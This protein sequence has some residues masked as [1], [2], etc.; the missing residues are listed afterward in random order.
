MFIPVCK[1]FPH[2]FPSSN[3]ANPGATAKLVVPLEVNSLE[4]TNESHLHCFS[5]A[6]RA[7][8]N[9]SKIADDTFCLGKGRHISSPKKQGWASLGEWFSCTGRPICFTYSRSSMVSHAEFEHFS[10]ASWLSAFGASSLR[11]WKY[12]LQSRLV[13][14]MI[15]EMIQHFSTN[16]SYDYSWW[17]RASWLG[18]WGVI[19]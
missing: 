7:R 15:N 4:R 8:N 2:N 18:S 11:C 10:W 16:G 6:W 9:G 1:G 19:P 3:C 13:L 12:F 14:V 5:I 17:F